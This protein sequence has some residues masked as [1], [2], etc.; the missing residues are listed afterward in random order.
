[1][2]INLCLSEFIIGERDSEVDSVTLTEDPSND[3]NA[4][5][6]SELVQSSS[7]LFTVNIFWHYLPSTSGVQKPQALP[8]ADSRVEV[9]CVVD[10]T[11][12]NVFNLCFFLGTRSRC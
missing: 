7:G 9:S 12:F 5:V 8:N 11:I 6:T 3:E 2:T 1:M 4:E 10:P